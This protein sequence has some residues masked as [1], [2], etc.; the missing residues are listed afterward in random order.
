MGVGTEVGCFFFFFFFAGWE[1]P[2]QTKKNIGGFGVV[3]S[4]RKYINS[5]HVNSNQHNK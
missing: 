1:D 5:K 3:V 2:K 4:L